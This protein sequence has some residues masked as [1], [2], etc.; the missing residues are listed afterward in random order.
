MEYSEV[1][2]DLKNQPQL[3]INVLIRIS[4]DQTLPGHGRNKS[5]H[6]HCLTAEVII[7]VQCTL[8]NL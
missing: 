1:F 6:D 7:F 5:L 2:P 3:L 8:L 4:P